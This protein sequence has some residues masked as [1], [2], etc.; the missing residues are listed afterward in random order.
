MKLLG[1]VEKGV[2]VFQA[3]AG[4]APL[5]DGTVVEVTPVRFEAGGPSAAFAGV[6]A[7]PKVPQ[8]EVAQSERAIAVG[9]RAAMTTD[10]F[11]EDTAG[12]VSKERQEALRQL[13]G[14]WKIENPPD[15][16]EVERILEEE[17]MKKY[18]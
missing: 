1:R 4:T 9:T 7:T 8:Q 10:P 16:E 14:L 12:R 3:G 13:I 15:D 17:R 6:E 2:V 11:A 18:G 5:P